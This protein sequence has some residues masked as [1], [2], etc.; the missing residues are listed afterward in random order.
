MSE[1]RR[2]WITWVFVAATLG[3]VALMLVGT[4]QRPERI[5]LPVTDLVPEQSVDDPDSDALTVVA[6]TPDTVQAA[7]A[8]LERPQAYRRT[9]TIEQ[10]WNGGSSSS[11]IEVTVRG[12]WTRTD[13]TMPGGQ[14][15]HTVTDGETTHIWYNSG[16]KIFTAAAGEISADMEQGIPT[17]EDVL[18][19]PKDAIVTADYRVISD[20]NCIYVETAPD[21]G[22]YALRYWVDV[23]TGLL[24]ASE[25]LAEGSA[26]YRMASLEADR[27]TPADAVFVLPDGT[28]LL[29]NEE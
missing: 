20:V 3:I 7:I 1:N 27:S 13:R 22:G 2:N 23:N 8:S 28:A 26:V 14:T 4:L 19:L 16:E 18:A 25:K 9:V 10:I 12:G 17:Y 15:R 6:V 5:Q 24:V 29:E 11:E 21:E